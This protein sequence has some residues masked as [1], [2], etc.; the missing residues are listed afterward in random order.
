MRR[1]IYSVRSNRDIVI[2]SSHPSGC[3]AAFALPDGTD[4]PTVSFG[5]DV[6]IEVT[7][8]GATLSGP[9]SVFRLQYED[10]RLTLFALDGSRLSRFVRNL[11]LKIVNG[12]R[13]DPHT[14]YSNP[15][16]V[17]RPSCGV[18]M[19][20]AV[21]LPFVMSM[22]GLT[23]FGRLA[24]I[25]AVAGQL[26]A[27]GFRSPQ[28]G[29]LAAVGLAAALGDAAVIAAVLRAASEMSTC[30]GGA[31]GAGGQDRRTS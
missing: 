29:A 16:E 7:S 11:Q 20:G 28:P 27:P 13:A 19:S 18:T 1:R 23:R 24:A 17:T 21:S 5:E 3:G 9:N 6:T 26:A 31:E 8:R 30:L 22:T 12:H 10:D 4:W 14:P 2:I 25:G 15:V